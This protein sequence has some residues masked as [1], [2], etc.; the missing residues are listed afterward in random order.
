M[1]ASRRSW[2]HLWTC[3]ALLLSA[4]N[5]L[6]VSSTSVSLRATFE[7][8]K[9]M[10]VCFDTTEYKC[11]GVQ[12][13]TG[14]C[15]SSAPDVVR[16]C[17]FG[18]EVKENDEMMKSEHVKL[19]HIATPPIN[20]GGS[21]TDSTLR[22]AQL[23]PIGD[24]HGLEVD[25]ARVYNRYG[26]YLVDKARQIGAP[27]IVLA[28]VLKAEALDTG[29]DK[30]LGK[31]IIRF[32]NQV[33]WDEWGWQHAEQYAK[34]F[35]FDH[36]DR[37]LGQMVRF[38]DLGEKYWT[39][40]HQSQEQE[41]K[42]VLFAQHLSNED[43]IKA[44]SMGICQVMGLHYKE[45]GYSKPQEMFRDLSSSIKAQIDAFFDLAKSHDESKQALQQ[46]NY[47]WFARVYNGEEKMNAKSA[48]MNDAAVT[49]KRLLDA[50]GIAFE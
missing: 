9:C 27:P 30:T 18:Y 35:G 29:F 1:A 37:H 14:M 45:A 4:H 19:E 3:V 43:A 28:S 26:R 31:M 39:P 11:V 20:G 25:V 48:E 50:K 5:A 15:S 41:W 49:L 8:S 10:G 21:E 42:V 22:P 47:A 13:E 40:H 32:H 2:P 17:P 7:E 23:L 16:C 12:P 33:F 38:E 34:H 36:D 6:H 24:Y 46:S 44:T